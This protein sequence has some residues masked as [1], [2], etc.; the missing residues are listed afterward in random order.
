MFYCPKCGGSIKSEENFCPSCGEKL[1]PEL[2]QQKLED[3]NISGVTPSNEES[4]TVNSQSE[5][6]SGKEDPKQSEDRLVKAKKIN[7]NSDEKEVIGDNLKVSF[8][9]NKKIIFT[10]ITL[11]A[12]VMIAISF[13][14]DDKSS[15]IYGS[16]K[17]NF[18]DDINT[19][20][21]IKYD[22]ERAYLSLAG[23]YFA[24]YDK[25][26]EDLIE[27]GNSKDLYN[28]KLKYN[29]TETRNLENGY[30][31]FNIKYVQLSGL[32]S[33]ESFMVV[34]S[35][36]IPIGSD[37]VSSV[38]SAS[39]INDSEFPVIIEKNTIAAKVESE[40][41]DVSKSESMVETE[42][43]ST[44]TSKSESAV[45][46]E[47]QATSLTM[48]DIISQGDAIN[49]YFDASFK[50]TRDPSV[51]VG[52]VGAYALNLT[53]KTNYSIRMDTHKFSIVQYNGQESVVEYPNST[54]VSTLIDN[55]TI[56][57]NESFTIE[58]LITQV[59]DQNLLYH[60]MKYD[61]VPLWR[62]N[63]DTYLIPIIGA[64]TDSETQPSMLSEEEMRAYAKSYVDN[65]NGYDNAIKEEYWEV[66][67]GINV[68]YYVFH[69]G[70]TQHIV[71]VYVN[72]DTGAV[73]GDYGG[74]Q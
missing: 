16:Y 44:T 28:I 52:M 58:N 73:T 40:N 53:N 19:P 60:I 51:K 39:K 42:S 43:E 7:E 59:A 64:L 57:P 54:R 12:I 6:D 66:I 10:I 24:V 72:S 1:T 41:K 18:E 36:T 49:T 46:S 33:E 70:P 65:W 2:F 31:N 34:I 45:K 48:E 63:I 67:D 13:L 20:V 22:G 71:G 30:N 69:D 62:N 23:D 38:G 15:D 11:I 14:R 21:Y 61:G 56:K 37:D 55:V 68:K 25:I 35:N 50:F 27:G 32:Y 4:S 74:I 5:S 3:D 8:W 29:A 47:S 26:S 9:K 17:G